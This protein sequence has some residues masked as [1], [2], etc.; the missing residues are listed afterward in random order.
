MQSPIHGRSCIDIKETALK[1]AKIIPELLALHALSG[2][3]TVAET[4]GIGKTKAI[5]AA[6]KGYTLNQLGHPT[7][8][9]TK[10]I[11]QATTFMG[12]CYGVPTPA[13]FMTR[14]VKSYRHR[15]PEKTSAAPKLCTLPPTTEAFE[16]NVLR[17]HHQLAQCFR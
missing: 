7:T 6:Q 17:A 14:S 2:C 13:A 10:I 11:I 4:Y 1:H 16:Q 9:M 3:D 5:A 8:D 12:A 15:R